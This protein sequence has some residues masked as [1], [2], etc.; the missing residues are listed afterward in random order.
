MNLVGSTEHYRN[1]GEAK[2]IAW[3]TRRERRRHRRRKAEQP[4]RVL[5]P[6]DPRDQSGRTRTLARIGLSLQ[7]LA[8]RRYAPAFSRMILPDITIKPLTVLDDPNS[9]VH[10]SAMHKGPDDDKPRTSSGKS[11]TWSARRAAANPS[12]SWSGT[13]IRV[14]GSRFIGNGTAPAIRSA[15]PR[16]GRRSF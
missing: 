9:W 6:G 14:I 4:D 5:Q 3:D 11:I 15:T 16:A 13:A 2:N 12:A 8:G 10:V 1:W 7:R